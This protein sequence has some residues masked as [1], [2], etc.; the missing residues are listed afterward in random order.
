[1][2]GVYKPHVLLLLLPY[3][4]IFKFFDNNKVFLPKVVF[5]S[6]VV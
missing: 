5:T 2:S 3:A 4:V 1:M 6:E